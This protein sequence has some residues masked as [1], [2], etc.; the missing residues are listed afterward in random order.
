MTRRQID[1]GVH[2]VEP[3]GELGVALQVP[4]KP[5]ALLRHVVQHEIRHQI[6]A[7]RQ[8]PKVLPRAEPRV[9][10]TKVDH[11]KTIV[12][13]VG[14]KGQ[15]VD[16]GEGIVQPEPSQEF[17]ECSQSRPVAIGHLVTVADQCDVALGPKRSIH[18]SRST[19]SRTSQLDLF[20]EPRGAIAVDLLHEAVDVGRWSCDR[21]GHCSHLFSVSSR[22]CKRSETSLA[23]AA[24]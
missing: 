8:P 21:V 20:G 5:V 24:R 3:F 13:R 18:R 2:S 10:P 4:T 11:G 6:D 12:G 17:T 14:T 16:D 7:L 22:I 19:V 15:D 9:D 23:P 1:G